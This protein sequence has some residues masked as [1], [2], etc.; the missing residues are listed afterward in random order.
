MRFVPASTLLASLP[1]LRAMDVVRKGFFWTSCHMRTTHFA[2]SPIIFE[3]TKSRDGALLTCLGP[4]RARRAYLGILA[5]LAARDKASTLVRG[6]TF[7]A[8]LY[9]IAAI[10]P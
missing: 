8:A 7:E 5:L 10:S 4:R 3:R 1:R 9:I 6:R 2:F